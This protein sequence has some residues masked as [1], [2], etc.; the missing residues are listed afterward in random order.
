MVTPGQVEA[1]QVVARLNEHQRALKE[2]ALC[3]S[4]CCGNLEKCVAEFCFLEN[5]TISQKKK[6]KMR[7]L[8]KPNDPEE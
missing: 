2:K 5:E 8:Q 3:C 1:T 6:K 7:K 4:L